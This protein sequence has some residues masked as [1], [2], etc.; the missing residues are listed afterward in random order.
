[1]F[2]SMWQRSCTYGSEAAQY[3]VTVPLRTTDAST[4]FSVAV[5]DI[6]ESTISR[7]PAT[8]CFI[9]S[10]YLP[11][12]LI[13]IPTCA[14]A[15]ICGS[16]I[17]D[18]IEHPPGFVSAKRGA[19]TGSA[20]HKSTDAR[21]F[22]TASCRMFFGEIFAAEIRS[23]RS[24]MN[25]CSTPILVNISSITK[26]SLTRGT[27]SISQVSFVRSVAAS[28]ANAAFFAPRTSIDPFS[29]FPPLM[30]NVSAMIT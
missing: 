16:R 19:R 23:F 10:R 14:S 8:S 27:L 20:P 29:F 22:S 2:T 21:I 17:R 15:S 3:I 28:T 9:T 26:T 24:E 30:M 13:S 18:P 7:S 5:T 1:M 12:F 6:S 4:A 11:R 25:S